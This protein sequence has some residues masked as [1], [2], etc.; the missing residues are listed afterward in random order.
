MGI[1]TT[2]AY[3]A[4]SL[5]NVTDADPYSYI[6]E[7]VVLYQTEQFNRAVTMSAATGDLT[8]AGSIVSQYIGVSVE[9]TV[10]TN[11]QVL[12]TGYISGQSR[13]FNIYVNGAF[14]L[15][16]AGLIEGRQAIYTVHSVNLDMKILNSGIIRTSDKYGAVIEAGDGYDEIVNTGEITGR[17]LMRAGGDR[18]TNTGTLVGDLDLGDGHDIFQ[19]IGGTMTGRVEGGLGSD[20]YYIDRDIEL[21]E[22]G[23]DEFDHVY[24]YFDYTLGS[25]FEILTLRGPAAIGNGNESDNRIYGNGRDNILY[26]LAGAD[27]L[28]GKGGADI[29]FG[30]AG[31]DDLEGGAGDNK[32]YGGA[33]DDYITALDGTDLISGGSGFDVALFGGVGGVAS[34]E[35]MAVDLTAQTVSGGDGEGDTISGIEAVLTGAGN[36]VLTGSAAANWLLGNAGDDVITGLAG[37][38]QLNGMRGADQIDGGTGTDTAE[39]QLSTA[40]VT[41][42]LATGGTAGGDA[43]GD[44]LIAIE[45]LTGSQFNDILTGNDG[46]N[47]IEGGVGNDKIAGGAGGD[48]ASYQGAAAGVKVELIAGAQDTVGAGVDTLTGIE[49]LLGSG[50]ADVLKGNA[51]ANILTGGLAADTLAGNGGADVFRYLDAADT[52]TTARDRILDFSS[53]DGDKISLAAIDSDTGVAGNQAFSFIGAASFSGSAGELRIHYV[54]D[55]AIVSADTDGDG[56]ADFAL[57]VDG[58]TAV[59]PLAAGDF[60][61]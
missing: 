12:S 8:V 53:A 46:A 24:A 32:L 2:S 13:A 9:G 19:N 26:G 22:V 57:R 3:G 55:A 61:L 28:D 25:G 23:D 4:G 49:H 14:T 21:V 44:V 37:H 6:V 34:S 5:L 36:D 42:N 60:V 35:A 48:T 56:L 43:A 33:G 17:V 38:D 52:A 39:Y 47:L 27:D 41:V 40:G 58:T 11:V 30:G 16:N 59:A 18:F 45:N 54:G 31:N 7:D 50:H 10:A 20:T 15:S 29:L 1:V 51:G